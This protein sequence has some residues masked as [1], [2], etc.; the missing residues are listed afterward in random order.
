MLI[1]RRPAYKQPDTKINKQTKKNKQ[2]KTEPM[3]FTLV[4]ILQ[5]SADII[6]FFGFFWLFVCLFGVFA[7]F[8]CFSVFSFFWFFGFVKDC[9]G[10][11]V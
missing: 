3:I 5:T 4:G 6:V 1:S 9:L 10:F 8:L 11:Q 2:T 7:F